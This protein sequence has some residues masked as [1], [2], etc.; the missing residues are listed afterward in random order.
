M[1]GRTERTD[2]QAAQHSLQPTGWIGAIQTRASGE[3]AVPIY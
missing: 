1:Y 3:I 2:R